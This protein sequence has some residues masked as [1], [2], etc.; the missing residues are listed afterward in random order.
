MN[1]SVILMIQT[2][3]KKSMKYYEETKKESMG[4]WCIL[5]RESHVG[6]LRTQKVFCRGFSMSLSLSGRQTPD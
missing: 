6:E 4:E 3:E 2:N 1:D 5:Y